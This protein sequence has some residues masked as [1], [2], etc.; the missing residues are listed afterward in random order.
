MKWYKLNLILGEGLI[1]GSKG[2][3]EILYR[4]L[5][6]FFKNKEYYERNVVRC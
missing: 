2:G 5:I 6:F 1:L 3:D 4:F